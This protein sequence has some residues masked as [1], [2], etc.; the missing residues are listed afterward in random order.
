[1]ARLFKDRTITEALENFDISDFDARLKILTSW[2]DAYKSGELQQKTESQCEQAFNN[3]VFIKVLDHISFPKESYTIDPKARTETSGQKPDAALGYFSPDT[4]HVHAVCEIKD[5]NTSLDKPQQREGNLTPVQQAFKYKPQYTR[6]DFVLVTNFYEM[7]IYRDNQLDYEEFTLKDLVDPKDNYYQFRK[8]Y[9]LLCRQNFIAKTGQSNTERILSA[10]RIE[11][12]EISKKFYTQYRQLRHELIS[13]IQ[14]NNPDKPA[15]L[16]IEKAQKIIDRIVFVS[17]CED[18]GLL[19][20]NKLMEVVQWAEKNSPFESGIW[21]TL[22]KFFAA[23]DHGS[24][25]LGIPDGYNG[26]LFKEDKELNELKIDDVIT[27]KFVDLGRFSFSDDLTVNILGHIFEQSISDLESLKAAVEQVEQKKKDSRRKKEGIYYTPEYIVSYIVN[28]TVGR[29]LE[30]QEAAIKQ[31]HG[32]KEDI[33]DKTYKKRA[34]MVYQEYQQVLQKIKVLDPACGSGAFLVKVFDYLLTENRR[35]AYVLSDLRGQAALL[36]QESL[37]K[38]IL[39]NNIYGVDLNPESVEI[40]KLSLWLKT[41]QKGKKLAT[42]KNTIR[43]GNSLIDDH[44]IA[45]IRAFNWS[46]EFPEIMNTGGF[47]VIVGNPPYVFARGGNFAQQEKDYYYSKYKLA[48]Y[49]INTFLLFIELSHNLLKQNGWLGFIVP[50]NWLTINSFAPLREFLLKNTGNL[51]IYNAINSVFDQA[52]VD[53][54]VLLFSK[55]PNQDITLG[56]I[57]A[58]GVKLIRKTRPEDFSGNDYVIKITDDQSKSLNLGN[59]V[60]L[61]SIASVKTGLKAYQVGKGKP[62][63]TEKEKAE[64][65]F[66]SAKKINDTYLPY[67]QGQDVKRYALTWS[68][69]FLSYGDW[70]AEPRKSVPFSGKR[71]LVRQIPSAPPYSINAVAVE[72]DYLNDI[73]SMVIFELDRKF[74]YEYLLAVINSK[75]ISFWFYHT[76][77]KFQRK[78]FPQFKVNEL[79]QFPIY[80]ASEGAQGE[81]VEKVRQL[82]SMSGDFNQKLE[83]AQKLF[84]HEFSLPSIPK[85]AK[86]FYKQ[87]FEDFLRTIKVSVSIQ[88]KSE[89]MDFFTTTKQ[90][91]LTLLQTIQKLNKEIDELVM[92]LYKI[93]DEEKRII[94]S[95][96]STI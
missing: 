13:N 11:E 93:S 27:K 82:L 80:K 20:D 92:N 87:E 72:S 88:K 45:G 23:V 86:S 51:S 30:E 55:S 26:E 3:D 17:F 90:E 49:Q 81:I 39:H 18:L 7:R 34:L 25:R 52:N 62:P 21:D 4:K 84:A 47:D 19:P 42:L 8:F 95:F 9:Y 85:K 31:K 1:M 37:I 6:C 89:L 44:A 69:E 59:T 12:E 48:N 65:V 22:V 75:L 32:L 68:G 29:Y 5:V 50:N 91:L 43:C 58:G 76:F 77:N 71:I 96:G 35:V 61:G 38:D 67:L 28:N 83:K 10:I 46:G 73:N 64:R 94:R 56:E 54:C 41:A 36:D 24:E 16:A 15:T 66:H 53:T 74:S 60:P 40:T 33:L 70:L 79:A 57:N 2:Y 14:K 63:Q 78:I